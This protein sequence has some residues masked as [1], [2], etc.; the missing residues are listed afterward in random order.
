MIER[1]QADTLVLHGLVVTM[2]N[3]WHV[4]DDGAVAISGQNIV[5]IG[6]SAELAANYQASDTLDASNQ[7]VM[8]GL[9][10]GHTHAPAVI[11]RGLIEDL[12]LE[13][14]LE[15]SW[16]IEKAMLNPQTIRLGAQ[17]AHIEM[18]QSG[19][20]TALDMYW[21]PE[22]SAE[23]AKQIGFRLIT[24][25]AYL[26]TPDPP[27]HVPDAQRTAQGR[28]F[29]QEY[30]NDP[31]IISC[32]Q[33]HSTYTVSPRYLAEAQELASEFQVLI[34]T[35]ASE[36]PVE[37]QI[38]QAKY[39]ATP[40]RHLDALGCLT[41]RTVLAH[42]TLLKP[43][44]IELVAE[45]GAAVAHCPISNLKL[46]AG[47]APVNRMLRRG[48][49]V[50]VG[51]DGAQSSNDLNLWTVMRMATLLQKGINNDPT[52]VPPREVVRMATRGAAEALGLGDRI[53]SL[54]IGK[55]ADLILL[56]LRQAH[57]LPLYDVYLHLVYSAGREDVATVI[58]NG[59]K[60]MQ[61]RH[62]LT[63][64]EL[65]SYDRVSALS[66][67]IHSTSQIVWQVQGAAA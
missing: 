47:I 51:T 38:V 22:V 49:H 17:L 41:N 43:D 60:V 39:G 28:E 65:E 61:E 2:D 58:I 23:V 10:N 19:T 21:F 24:G 31:L 34:N 13:P 44:D 33:P 64:D 27:D 9:I 4:L 45:R 25:P 66:K 36:S 56:D 46:G 15:K 26:E 5:A 63:I 67:Q 55:R 54:E 57:A 35:H 37:M 53:G 30:R 50:M 1:Q 16:K 29:L 52:L 3:D 11:F 12:E 7:I 14:W 32:V 42:G 62:M 20:T 59:R 48:V 8:P 6:P 18:I 40:P